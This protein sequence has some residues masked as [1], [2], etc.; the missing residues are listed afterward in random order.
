M[1]DWYRRI[2]L[3]LLAAA[4]IVV[5]YAFVYQ[6][7]LYT[8]ENA[9]IS[10]FESIQTVI[11]VLT[12][13]GFGGDTDHWNSPQINLL[14]VA[15][16]L[17]GVLLVF[18]AL[19][20][21]AVPMF[22]QALETEPPTTSTLSNHVIICGHS[23]RDEVLSAELEDAGIPYLYV[24]SDRE[25]V[26][27]LRERGIEA[28]HGDTELVDTFEAVNASE[29]RAVVADIDDEI[30]PTVIL[31]A[32]RANPEVQIVSVARDTS[33][34]P[35]HR[36]AGADE[37]VEGPQVLG[38]GLGMRAVTSFAE[39]F[40]AYVDVETDLRVTELLVEENSM[41]T[42]D[43]LGE[44]T[45]FDDLNAT[46]IGGWFD[47][48]FVVS[49]GPETTIGEN[50]ILLVA[51]H[52]E[53]LSELTAR[54][55]PTH[56]DDPERV[57]VCGHGV[58]GRAVCDTLETEGID[59]DV[60]DLEDHD[61]TDI[62]GDVTDPRTLR[63]ADVENARAV[64]LALDRDT[65]TIFAALVLQQLAPDVEIIARVHEHDNVWKLY[66]AGADFVLSMSVLTGKLL[67]SHLIDDKEILT[68][69]AEFEFVRTKAPALEGQT[70]AD[71]DVRS[72]TNCTIV[73]VE[74]ENDLLTDLGGSFE[75]RP[76]DVLI[77]SGTADATEAFIEFA[78]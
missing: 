47:G 32:R 60:V 74:R 70:L 28:V 31:S 1:D 19:P 18:L 71:V 77:V 39:K 61:G 43:T 67:A 64:V 69:Q 66:N 48:K 37:L 20:L 22:R 24:D 23:A 41:L 40:R 12:T 16:N 44:T 4:A 13:A 9:Q 75:I 73:A 78:H 26:R 25:L 63:Q 21:F 35:Y 58:V 51:G 30:N 42:G 52:Y 59:Y 65:T 10:L 14:V 3:A 36:L 15:M 56:R 54:P 76:D 46:V 45:V 55:L 62:V 49:P 33:V 8:F 6:W 27:E 72:R 50:T 38:E 68:P 34:A 53:D 17:T 29:A 57:V 5:G 7:A 2:T 11:E